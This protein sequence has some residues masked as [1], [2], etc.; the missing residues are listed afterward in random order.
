MQTRTVQ[1]LKNRTT[2]IAS[3]RIEGAQQ[4]F[5]LFEL[6]GQR[7]N[8]HYILVT[9]SSMHKKHLWEDV[10]V[11]TEITHRFNRLRFTIDIERQWPD[12][13]DCKLD[14]EEKVREIL[15][16]SKITA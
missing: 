7:D 11:V 12:L 10:N 3:F 13:V 9:E 4:N 5:L 6:N 2:L 16:K 15:L 1:T 8:K 14:I